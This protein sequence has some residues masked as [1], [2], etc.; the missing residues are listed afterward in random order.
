[1]N[2]SNNAPRPLVGR[3]PTDTGCPAPRTAP[4]ANRRWAIRKGNG[5]SGRCRDGVGPAV[6]DKQGAIRRGAGTTRPAARLGHSAGLHCGN[7]AAVM[8]Q[9][10]HV[11]V[12]LIHTVQHAVPGIQHLARAAAGGLGQSL[13]AAGGQIIFQRKAVQTAVAQIRQE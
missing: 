2:N 7:S 11:A 3:Q 6:A 13:Y 12:Q 9:H 8:V 4:A 5:G 1:M 10:P